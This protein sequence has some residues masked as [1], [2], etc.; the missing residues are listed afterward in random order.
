MFEYSPPLL[1]SEKPQYIC[2]PPPKKKY[3]N[4]ASYFEATTA[5]VSGAYFAYVSIT[6]AELMPKEPL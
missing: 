2:S 1:K 5:V 4:K 6:T 3:R